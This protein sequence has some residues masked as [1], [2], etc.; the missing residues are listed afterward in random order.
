[1]ESNSKKDNTKRIFL[2]VGILFLLLG[3]GFSTVWN[4]ISYS[5]GVQ[6][7]CFGIGIIFLTTIITERFLIREYRDEVSKVAGELFNEFSNKPKKKDGVEII[8]GISLLF[9][10]GR[11]KHQGPCVMFSV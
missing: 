6:T 3:G 7:V 10:N 1:M 2:E 8:P 5:E 4:N 11:F 9:K